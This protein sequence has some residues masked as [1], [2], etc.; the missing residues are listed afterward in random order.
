VD[1]ASDEKNKGTPMASLHDNTVSPRDDRRDRGRI[2][3]E[4]F[5]HAL[6]AKWVKPDNRPSP[7]DVIEQSHVGRL[8]ELAPLRYGRMLVSPFTFY[9]GTAGIMAFDLNS[10]GS[11]N[12]RVQACGDSHMLN[13]GAFA[14]P[15][16][17]IIFDLNDF[18]ETL[19]APWEW[20]VKR[21]AVSFVLACRDNGLKEKFARSSA[22]A[23]AKAYRK[24][25]TE[26]S[27][28]SILDIWYDRI[29]WERVIDRTSDPELQ[30][31]IKAR[32]E[33]A[34]KR[35][36]QTHYFPKM[37]EVQEGKFIF[38]DNP[39]S[40]Y[41]LKGAEQDKFRENALEAFKLYRGT[42][43]DDKQRLF[44][45]YKL[46]DVAIKV[47]GVGS[48][49]TYCAVALMLAP[50]TEPLILQLKEAKAS[51]L[52]PFAGKSE[53]V[54][55]GQRVVAGQRIIQS[56]SDI[57]LGW[58]EFADGRHFYI[59]QL[60]DAKVKLEPELWDGEHMQEIAEIMGIV[61]ARAHARS[62]DAAVVSGYLGEESTFDEAIGSFALAYADQAEADYEEFAQ[63]IRSGRLQAATDLGL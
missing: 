30:R 58:T 10:M 63:A 59:R 24:K 56:A 60:R 19:P 49:G 50:D 37:T 42:L 34:L 36:I 35:T 2:L 7:V 54:N 28:K 9:R 31:K 26:Y 46:S 6:H 61:L 14:T 52:E 4:A 62:G 21:L 3:H 38:K 53:F 11:T 32:T 13:F 29:D 8:P 43:Q 48:V 15:E 22:E 18:D 39:P 45:R 51:V 55:H 25:M 23:V 20:D 44:D 57:F 17:N 33:K 47:V 5:P 16:R 1:T 12:V 40:L 27:R 41:H